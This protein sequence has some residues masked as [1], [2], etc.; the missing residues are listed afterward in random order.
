ML[1]RGFFRHRCTAAVKMAA[2]MMG[3]ISSGVVCIGAARALN[4]RTVIATGGTV[5]STNERKF[6][7]PLDE[8]SGWLRK[9]KKG[10]IL[11]KKMASA[12]ARVRIIASL[13]L[14][15]IERLPLVHV[16]FVSFP[17]V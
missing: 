13:M 9:N 2:A 3:S 5:F 17:S 15:I 12:M 6:K 16:L 11:Q 10:K 1:I 7:L 4:V 14:V 8:L